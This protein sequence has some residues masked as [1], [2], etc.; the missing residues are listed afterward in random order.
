MEDNDDLERIAGKTRT[1]SAELRRQIGERRPHEW[2][3]QILDVCL[4]PKFLAA[5][6][7]IVI[8]FVVIQ[9]IR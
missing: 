7:I 2:T 8:A 6:F 5:S 3:W 9:I 4:N 1:E